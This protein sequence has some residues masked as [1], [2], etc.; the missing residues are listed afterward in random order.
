MKKGDYVDDSSGSNNNKI[1]VIAYAIEYFCWVV[2]ISNAN[3][4]YH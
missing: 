2:V 1:N 4:D 3:Y